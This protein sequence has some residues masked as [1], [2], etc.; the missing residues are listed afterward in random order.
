MKTQPPYQHT[1]IGWLALAS[2]LVPLVVLQPIMGTAGSVAP[3]L[4]AAVVLVVTAGLFATLT[5]RV[6]S[7]ELGLRFGHCLLRPRFALASVAT[8]GEIIKPSNY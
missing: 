4:I 5:V 8:F 7:V 1:Q 6:D 3:A 2:S